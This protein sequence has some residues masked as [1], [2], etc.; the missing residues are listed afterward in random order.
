V[1]C[2]RSSAVAFLTARP[3]SLRLDEP[4]LGFAP[5][6]SSEIFDVL[7]RLSGEGV[8]ILVVEQT[9]A[10]APALAHHAEVLERGHI[11]LSGAPQRSAR[12]PP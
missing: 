1:R 2:G 5:Q 4:S 10:Q 8:T 3:R 9:A 6:L 11:T 12:T 7:R